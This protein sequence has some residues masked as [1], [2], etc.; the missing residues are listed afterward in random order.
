MTTNIPESMWS[1]E[2][3][4]ED[5]VSVDADEA[6]L[7][8]SS[9]SRLPKRMQGW[10]GYVPWVLH[11]VLLS[12][13][14]VLYVLSR[15]VPNKCPESWSPVVGKHTPDRTIRFHGN[16]EF[17]SP[18]KGPPSKAVDD[19]WDL[20]APLGVMSVSEDVYKTLNASKHATKVPESAGGGYM[21]VFEGIHLVHCVRS[22]WETT[23][24]DYYTA[25]HEMFL[26]SPDEWHTHLDH[27][28]DML[29]QKLMCDADPN[30]V[31]YN[32][33]KRHK[34]PHPN[35]NVQHQCRDY[36]RLLEAQRRQRIDG[37]PF[38]NGW[39]PRP[40]DGPVAEF[41]EPPFDPDA[42]P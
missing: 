25:Q 1:K 14:L 38:A 7:G 40:S 27:C 29:R 19:A 31:T 28:A 42:D 18:Y 13:S 33:V 24:P 3:R 23:Y 34:A 6:L 10:L 17:R 26:K 2:E 35:F 11:C 16:L 20:V 37:T 32:W 12:T 21:S 4:E 41:E 39:I 30:L 9:K 15:R 8:G 22:L 36:S 5:D